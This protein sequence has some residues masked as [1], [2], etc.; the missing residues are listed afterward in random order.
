ME[1]FI[2]TQEE[3]PCVEDDKGEKAEDGDGLP[4]HS[5]SGKLYQIPQREQNIGPSRSS[6]K[7]TSRYAGF[8]LN[9]VIW[10]REGNQRSPA[11]FLKCRLWVLS[12]W[13]SSW[14]FC[15]VGLFSMICWICMWMACRENTP[16][17][18]LVKSILLRLMCTRDTLGSYHFTQLL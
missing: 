7:S 11:P 6:T 18:Y 15:A 9:S 17:V 3:S 5:S 13:Q 10:D 12:P 2:Q 8:T 14:P 4:G 1:A 16:D